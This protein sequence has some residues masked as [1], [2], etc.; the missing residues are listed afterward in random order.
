M[1]K[2]TVIVASCLLAIGAAR[3]AVPEPMV[4]A[5]CMA[6]HAEDKKLV[7]P[8]YKDVAA[9]YKGK[10]VKADLIAKVR[11]GGSGVWGPVPMTPTGPDKISDADL[12]AGIDW[13]LQH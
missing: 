8:S 9:K 7:G 12:A 6:C 11:K 2:Q 4:K 10:D 5:G 1:L 13:V 3:A